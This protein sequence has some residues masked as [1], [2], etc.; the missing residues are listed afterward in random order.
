MR[1]IVYQRQKFG[2]IS[3]FEEMDAHIDGVA[4]D[5]LEAMAWLVADTDAFALVAYGGHPIDHD[6]D[7]LSSV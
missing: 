1:R 6:V 7:P 4:R 5:E 3:S 2:R